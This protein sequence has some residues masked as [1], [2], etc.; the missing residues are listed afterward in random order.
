MELS[1]EQE[2]ITIT[3]PPGNSL[4]VREH[5]HVLGTGPITQGWQLF[6]GILAS[7]LD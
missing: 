3:V 2:I 6:R 7:H 5:G 4:R 1:S